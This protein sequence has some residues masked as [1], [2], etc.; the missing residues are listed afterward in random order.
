MLRPVTACV[1]ARGVHSSARKAS[2]T[3]TTHTG[4]PLAQTQSCSGLPSFLPAPPHPP[5]PA[6][7]LC[8]W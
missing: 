1:G 2:R 6:G 3:P 4:R 5:L 7:Q 8:K